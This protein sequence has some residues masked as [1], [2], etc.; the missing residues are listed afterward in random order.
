MADL[1]RVVR[2]YVGG[3]H[4][5]DVYVDGV[6]LGRVRRLGPSWE[7]QGIPTLFRTRKRA[8]DALVACYRARKEQADA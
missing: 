3:G 7:A 1:I 2:T 5:F 8:V 6:H 4:R